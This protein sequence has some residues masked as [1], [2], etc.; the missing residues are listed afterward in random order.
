[1]SEQI[2]LEYAEEKLVTDIMTDP[3]L[4]EKIGDDR[5]T[6][7]EF[8]FKENGKIIPLSINTDKPIGLSLFTLRDHGV[9]FHPM[10]L[11]PFR[12]YARESIKKSI[13]WYFKHIG[14]VLMCEIPIDH[15][16]TINLAKKMGFKESGVNKV[17][18]MR[19]GKK[20]E[21]QIL[22]LEK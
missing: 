14:S 13:D 5:I 19:K 6:R 2:K 17:G 22:R 16:S 12:R 9:Y 21:L 4:W 8:K 15:K 10:I 20:T 7:K 18:V 1:M 3:E 11:K